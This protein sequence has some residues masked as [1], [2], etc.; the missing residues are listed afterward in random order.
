[1]FEYMACPW[2]MFEYIGKMQCGWYM[3][4]YM[5]CAM[6]HYVMPSFHVGIV[7]CVLNG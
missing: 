3:F 7:H 2:Y 1:M 4:E 6:V 5:A